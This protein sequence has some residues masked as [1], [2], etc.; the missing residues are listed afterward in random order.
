MSVCSFKGTGD[1]NTFP[2]KDQLRKV[3]LYREFVIQSLL[4][5]KKVLLRSDIT[6]E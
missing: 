3:L 6:T 5:S 2:E 4:M 1:E